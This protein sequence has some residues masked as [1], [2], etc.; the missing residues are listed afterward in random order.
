MALVKRNVTY[1][2]QNLAAMGRWWYNSRRSGK[3]FTEVWKMRIKANYHTHTKRCRHANGSDRDYIEA[4]ISAG[5]KT[6]GFSDHVP[7]PYRDTL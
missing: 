4:A 7:L 6:L 5:I 2:A 3:S 1:M